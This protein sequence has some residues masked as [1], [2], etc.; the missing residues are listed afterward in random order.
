METTLYETL[1]VERD[2]LIGT[3]TVNRPKS[4]NALNSTVLR[5]L[6]RAAA[7]L[8][9]PARGTPVRALILTGAGEKAFVAGAD[10]AEMAPMT[11]WAGQEFSAL[12]HRTMATLES[13]P[14]ATIAAI[15]GFALGGGLELAMA[16]DL[17]YCAETA[18]L[19]QPEVNLGVAPG[20]G[21][22]QRLSRLVGKSRAKELIFTAEA[23]DAKKALEVGLVL[24][25]FPKEQLLPHCRAVAAKIAAKG[26]LAVAMSKR[27]IEQ[28][29]DQPLGAANHQEAQAFGLLFDTADRREGMAAFVEKRAAVFT[30]K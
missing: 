28:G 16:C 19:G 26:P 6:A 4:L 18:K 12:G 17:L 29:Y 2:G 7:E 10:I 23:I 15:N 22:S 5:E 24:G 14:C 9:D 11:A 13:L 25:V 8:C 1:L 20:F 27:L 21:G 3:I 30:G